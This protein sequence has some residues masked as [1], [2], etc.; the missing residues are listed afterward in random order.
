M[1]WSMLDLFS[2]VFRATSLVFSM[3]L[4]GGRWILAAWATWI[5]SEQVRSSRAVRVGTFKRYPLRRPVMA[6]IGLMPAFTIALAHISPQ[7]FWEALVGM[8]AAL[9]ISATLA[10]RPWPE[11]AVSPST[12]SPWPA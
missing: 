5:A 11:G 3:M 7:M 9:N 4:H 12:V 8:P 10:A 1:S 2:A 6:V